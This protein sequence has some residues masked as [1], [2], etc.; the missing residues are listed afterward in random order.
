MPTK[1]KKKKIT[2]KRAT[3]LKI[4]QWLSDAR[5]GLYKYGDPYTIHAKDPLS[6][7]LSR[8]F[9]LLMEHQF[10]GNYTITKN[11]F[12]S[13]RSRYMNLDYEWAERAK[14]EEKIKYTSSPEVYGGNARHVLRW[15]WVA[16][17]EEYFENC[18]KPLVIRAREYPNNF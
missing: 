6:V 2:K 17:T 1:V 4:P 11:E 9:R 13:L 8:K 5:E 16:P 10:N 3:V 15:V 14:S 12:L 18:V 7:E